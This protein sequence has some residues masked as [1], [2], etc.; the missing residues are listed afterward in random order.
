MSVAFSQTVI[1]LSDATS[2]TIVSPVNQTVGVE[3]YHTT[4]NPNFLG[5]GAQW[6]WNNAS[7]SWPNGYNS[8]FQRLFY[9]DCPQTAAVLT[10]TADNIFTAYLDGV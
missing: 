5:D 8:T 4:N 7:D 3:K 2:T 6:I 10:V 9:A 1:V